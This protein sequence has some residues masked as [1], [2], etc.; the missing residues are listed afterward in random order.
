MS[1]QKMYLHEKI[2]KLTQKVNYLYDKIQCLE[3]P[4]CCVPSVSGITRV[5]T[6]TPIIGNGRSNN[7]IRLEPGTVQNQVLLWD[8]TS[9]TPDNLPPT[10]I[11]T[12]LP[13]IGDGNNNPITLTSGN[14]GQF[15]VND[16]T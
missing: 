5:F 3:K 10:I 12:N 6:N 4:I 16:G 2:K 8:G 7:R 14:D 9:W 13:V 11:N 1:E 15:L